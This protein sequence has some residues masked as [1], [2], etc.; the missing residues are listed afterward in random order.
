MARP[1]KVAP[2]DAQPE[3]T[4]P[5]QNSILKNSRK[6]TRVDSKADAGVDQSEAIP[7]KTKLTNNQS[8]RSRENDEKT[9]NEAEQPAPP[10]KAKTVAEGVKVNLKVL[11]FL[12]LNICCALGPKHDKKND[13]TYCC[14]QSE[15]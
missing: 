5:P 8:K 15:H 12:L 9:T 4:P 3:K 13:T 6:R 7:K 10:K 1:K 11:K 2:T 14:Q